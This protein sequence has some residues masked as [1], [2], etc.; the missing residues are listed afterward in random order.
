M[1]NKRLSIG[2]KPLSIKKLSAAEALQSL[3]MYKKLT[4][5]LAQED[6]DSELLQ[7]IC[8]NAVLG[9]FSIYDKEERAF[10]SPEQV[11]DQLS[12]D[13][14]AQIY[15]TYTSAFSVGYR[16]AF[17]ENTEEY[18]SERPLPEAK[19]DFK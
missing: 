5:K 2:G 1:I 12:L 7:A 15:H 19:G 11:L 4:Q 3:A 10:H 8:E 17:Q 13:E 9:Y 6:M 14:L 16:D 18:F